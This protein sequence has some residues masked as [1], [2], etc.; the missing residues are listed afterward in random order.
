M[1]AGGVGKQAEGTFGAG[2]AHTVGGVE[3]ATKTLVDVQVMTNRKFAGRHNI[4]N[5]NI[6]PYDAIGRTQLLDIQEIRSTGYTS[7]GVAAQQ[8]IAT[9]AAPV[10][11]AP[12]ELI[13]VKVVANSDIDSRGNVGTSIMTKYAVSTTPEGDPIAAINFSSPIDEQTTVSDGFDVFGNASNQTTF[14]RWYDD[15]IKDG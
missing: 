13:D 14:K 15:S 5:Q 3:V 10:G 4:E 1:L 9:Y 2:V 6:S 8:V 11:T 12:A 7:S